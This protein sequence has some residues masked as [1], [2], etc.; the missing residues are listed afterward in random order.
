MKVKVKWKIEV[1]ETFEAVIEIDDDDFAEY[2][3]EDNS[4]VALGDYLNDY[5]EDFLPGEETKEARQFADVT[6]RSVRSFQVIEG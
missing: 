6:E 4:E 5:A 3:E 1:T 2:A